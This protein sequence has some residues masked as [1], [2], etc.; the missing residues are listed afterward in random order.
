MISQ[1]HG[2]KATVSTRPN[3]VDKSEQYSWRSVAV[4]EIHYV[5]EKQDRN[6]QEETFKLGLER[7]P[8]R[9]VKQVKGSAGIKKIMCVYKVVR[10][11]GRQ[12]KKTSTL[13]GRLRH[14]GR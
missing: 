14:A 11:S 10:V 2:H 13:K 4:P 3:L 1:A 12:A 8:V 5:K 6:T 9:Q 7:C